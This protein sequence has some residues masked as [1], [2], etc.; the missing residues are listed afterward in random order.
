MT[1]VNPIASCSGRTADEMNYL[2]REG[3]IDEAALF[4]WAKT[5]NEYVVSIQWEVVNAIGIMGYPCKQLAA[6]T[7][8]QMR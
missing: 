6:N 1:A 7:T 8:E 3:H 4:E 5:Q 2:A